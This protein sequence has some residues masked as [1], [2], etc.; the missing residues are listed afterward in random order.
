MWVLDNLCH[1]GGEPMASPNHIVD[2]S[3]VVSLLKKSAWEDVCSEAWCESFEA[4]MRDSC[5]DDVFALGCI[6]LG[7]WEMSSGARAALWRLSKRFVE[8]FC[9]P[10]SM[11]DLGYDAFNKGKGCYAYMGELERNGLAEVSHDAG[12]KSILYAL[13]VK[14]AGNLFYGRTDLPH[15]G[16]L[17]KYAHV[18][19]CDDIELKE[20]HHGADVREGLEP[21]HMLVSE[22][23]YLRAAEI[24]RRKGRPA[25]VTA[26]LSGASGTGKTETVRQMARSS[27]RDLISIDF[28]RMTHSAWGDSEKQYRA[29]FRCYRYAVAVNSMFPIL[30]L[31]EADQFL[32]GRI[33]VERSIDKAENAVVDILLEEF[34]HFEGILFATT[35]IMASVDS[36]FNRR[37]LF[38]VDFGT[39]DEEARRMIWLSMVAEL[40]CE[41]ASCLATYP[42]TGA[43]IANIVTRRDLVELY[44]K[45]TPGYEFLLVHCQREIADRG[46]RRIGFK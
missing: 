2:A 19:R 41:E 33:A 45:D 4:W 26:M 3:D 28:S 34:E 46:V 10:G 17:M 39:P 11:Y 13:T 36:A 1:H 35:N 31:N 22:E 6:W 40:S 18:T 30:L 38:K 14:A 21:L 29:L 12:S 20:L 37:F 42:L 32:S 9:E 27:G 43:Q 23:G 7:V 5:A 15:V 25:G 8:S 16:A 44:S 24:M